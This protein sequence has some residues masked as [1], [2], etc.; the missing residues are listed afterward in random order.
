[1]AGTGDATDWTRSA[2]FNEPT[3]SIVTEYGIVSLTQLQTLLGIAFDAQGLKN[4]IGSNEVTRPW[5]AQV[6]FNP[7]VRE[8]SAHIIRMIQAYPHAVAHIIHHAGEFNTGRKN[9]FG[10]LYAQT[11]NP[12]RPLPVAVAAPAHPA[13]GDVPVEAKRLLVT[14]FL[15]R[16][17]SDGLRRFIGYHGYGTSELP[18]KISSPALLADAAADLLIRNNAVNEALLGNLLKER[19]RAFEEI[20]ALRHAF[21]SSAPTAARVVAPSVPPPPVSAP[22]PSPSPAAVRPREHVSTPM[23]PSMAPSPIPVI[24]QPPVVFV[25][26]PPVV[27]ISDDRATSRMAALTDIFGNE[28]T[29]RQII[30][31][32]HIDPATRSSLLG[33]ICGASPATLA[34]NF[35]DLSRRHG[36]IDQIIVSAASL[37]PRNESLQ[38]LAANRGLAASLRTTPPPSPRAIDPEPVS[39]VGSSSPT[40]TATGRRT[41][42]DS[43]FER[44][45][46]PL[47]DI[48][49]DMNII[50]RIVDRLDYHSSQSILGGL[51]SGS[52]ALTLTYRFIDSGKSHGV[53][54]KILVAA[55]QEFP[56]ND[57]LCR[58]AADRGF[59]IPVTAESARPANPT[60]TDQTAWI[61]LRDT[62]SRTIMRKGR[63]WDM[64]DE[65]SLHPERIDMNGSSTEVWY[66]VFDEARKNGEAGL[67]NLVTVLSAQAELR[68]DPH[69]AAFKAK[70]GIA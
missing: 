5:L 51:S 43:D 62:L 69:L 44:A 22:M 46:Y 34:L 18:G 52:S 3:N 63:I 41:M 23:A 48:F 36:M 25:V 49:G 60:A 50:R 4:L 16:F 38:S 11:A 64:A 20:D 66:A 8:I 32:A 61:A 45:L 33:S 55:L 24:A 15:A 67:R 6:S 1:M 68:D 47:T 53:L 35:A 70:L 13:P 56:E 26:A 65:A 21:R 19:P 28:T 10:A 2:C 37:Y 31:L 9:Q 7:N 27:R 54:D 59:E 12:H 30:Y 17:D 39:V 57:Q 29:I 40:V 42:S 58:L 14:F